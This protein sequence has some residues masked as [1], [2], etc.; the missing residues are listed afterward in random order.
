MFKNT[1]DIYFIY[2]LGFLFLIVLFV[3]F[4]TRQQRGLKNWVFLTC[5]FLA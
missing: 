3:V 5:S 4:N 2:P 1:F